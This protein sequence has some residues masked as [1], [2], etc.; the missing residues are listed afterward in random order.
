MQKPSI[1]R[2]VHFY[3][4]GSTT[5]EAAIVVAV[6][7]E[8]CVNLVCFN[9]GGTSHTETSTL[10]NGGEVAGGRRWEWPPRA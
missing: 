1:G 6:H 4:E 9:A 8:I 3:A 7:S 5:P 2:I 10:G